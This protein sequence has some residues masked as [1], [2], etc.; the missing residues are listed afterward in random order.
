METKQNKN[1]ELCREGC[2]GEEVRIIL[3]FKNLSWLGAGGGEGMRGG[4]GSPVRSNE[5]ACWVMVGHVCLGVRSWEENTAPS[6]VNGEVAAARSARR[7]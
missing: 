6:L 4:W 7:I 3:I 1:T 5:V 2:G